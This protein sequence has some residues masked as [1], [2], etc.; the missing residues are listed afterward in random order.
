MATSVP[1]VNL[2]EPE[3]ITSPAP[4]YISAGAIKRKLWTTPRKIRP[5][6]SCLIRS[7]A[8]RR[9]SVACRSITVLLR[10]KTRVRSAPETESVSCV[11]ELISA[12]ASCVDRERRRLVFPARWAT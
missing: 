4:R 2:V 5:T 8:K 1:G 9:L 12:S 6:I 3:L 11:I 10:S 7:S